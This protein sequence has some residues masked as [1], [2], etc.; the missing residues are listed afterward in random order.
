MPRMQFRIG[1]VK[2]WID[3]NLVPLKDNAGNVTSV[4]GIAR[5]ITERKRAE[6]ALRQAHNKLHLLSGITRHDIS[7]QL[8]TLNGFVA[9][10]QRGIQDPVQKNYFSRIMEASSN[11]TDM[12]A[13]TKEYEKIGTGAPVW[14]DLT[15]VITTAGKG[16][17]PGQFTLKNDL[18]ATTDVFAD[19]MLEKVFFNLLDNAVRHGERVT[20]I[21][22]SSRQSEENLV[23]VWEDNGIGIA[24]DEKERIFERGFG[25]NTGLGMFLVREILSLTGITIKET[26]EPSKGA[27]FEMVIAKGGYRLS[28]VQVIP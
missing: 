10:L 23:I 22:V 6:E 15:T 5:D 27:R 17:I 2:L 21:R 11:I 4:L 16:I 20:E 1:S 24:A 19:P 13:F 8:L 26:G 14:Q 28:D 3:T 18:P 12:I 7:N 25:K 9:L